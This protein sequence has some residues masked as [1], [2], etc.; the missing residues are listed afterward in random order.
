MGKFFY[1]KEH[2]VEIDILNDRRR[3]GYSEPILPTQSIIANERRR[4][5]SLF[6]DHQIGNR[7]I[8]ILP[9]RWVKRQKKTEYDPYAYLTNFEK[10]PH[11]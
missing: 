3:R 9:E 10:I 1:K 5:L 11:A 4:A 2:A 6:T 7:I 8:S